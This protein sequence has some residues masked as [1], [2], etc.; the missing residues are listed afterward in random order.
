M[1][2]KLF[3]F[4]LL[5]PSF[6]LLSKTEGEPSSIT[7]HITLQFARIAEQT[8]DQELIDA[9][10]SR[11]ELLFLL[12]DYMGAIDDLLSA[13]FLAGTCSFEEQTS[14]NLR[15]LIALLFIYAELHW[16]PS[17][18]EVM[19]EI[20]QLLANHAASEADPPPPPFLFH[21]LKLIAASVNPQSAQAIMDF[22]DTLHTLS[23]NN[24]NTA[25]ILQHSLTPLIEKWFRWKVFG[26]TYSS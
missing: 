16:E 17:L 4:L 19:E 9:Y 26:T 3:F 7:S 1:K 15:A 12:H 13:Q 22:S 20:L 5:C 24:A 23:L 21:Q 6:F 2:I 18:N 25:H 8:N 10:L 14:Y 11:G